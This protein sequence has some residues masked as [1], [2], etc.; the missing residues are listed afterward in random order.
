MN[1]NNLISFYTNQSS[2]EGEKLSAKTVSDC[3][4]KLESVIHLLTRNDGTDV[5]PQLIKIMKDYIEIAL[6]HQEIL[7][8][9]YS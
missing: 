6:E 7:N 8:G 2:L 9:C 1:S 3:L 5:F 4:E